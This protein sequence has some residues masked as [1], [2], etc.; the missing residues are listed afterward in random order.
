MSSFYSSRSAPVVDKNDET[1]TTI[2]LYFNSQIGTIPLSGY[3][4]INAGFTVQLANPIILDIDHRY[5]MALIKSSI[6]ITE[7]QDAYYTFDFN[8]D[9]IEFQYEN[10]Q[11]TQV[12]HQSYDY[13][14]V[15]ASTEAITPQYADV[16][17]INWKFINPTQKIISRISFWVTNAQNGE[18]IKS[19][20][21]NPYP[22]KINVL[23]KKV[24][25][26]VVAVSAY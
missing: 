7:Y 22:T 11:K 4:N 6:D 25:S 14:Y 17:N 26:K 3:T 21:E 24:N 19:P 12:L 18:P 1:Y 9:L 10:N 5:V 16:Q 2:E 8:C 13:K 23:I 15:P 20:A